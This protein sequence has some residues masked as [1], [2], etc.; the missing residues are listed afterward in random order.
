[1]SPMKF[2][3]YVQRET[4]YSPAIKVSS[5]VGNILLQEVIIDPGA[6]CNIMDLETA[7]KVIQNTSSLV[8]CT[9]RNQMSV[10][11]IT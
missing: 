9:D 6:E 1:M 5:R 2:Q 10:T 4:A 7:E 11:G 8:L 3:Q